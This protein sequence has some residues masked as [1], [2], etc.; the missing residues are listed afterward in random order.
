MMSPPPTAIARRGHIVF[1]ADPIGVPSFLC[2]LNQLID[3]HQTCI[4]G[5]VERVDSILVTTQFSWSPSYKGY[6]SVIS[7]HYLLNQWVI[8]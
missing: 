7:A 1:V 3:F 6:T 5:S 4:V 2:V 8:F